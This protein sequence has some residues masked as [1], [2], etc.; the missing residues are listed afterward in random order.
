MKIDMLTP[1]S[2]TVRVLRVRLT[3]QSKLLVPI[4]SGMILDKQQSIGQSLLKALFK[5]AQIYLANDKTLL[6]PFLQRWGINTVRRRLCRRFLINDY[7]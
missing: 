7:N 2:T 6:C 1:I 5:L 4:K 3:D